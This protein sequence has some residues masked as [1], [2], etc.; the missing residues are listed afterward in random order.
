MVVSPTHRPPLPPGNIPGTH[1]CYRLSQPQ[2]HSVARRYFPLVHLKNYYP[3]K[4]NK[5]KF[6][7]KFIKTKNSRGKE[8]SHK[9]CRIYVHM[10][11]IHLFNLAKSL[12]RK[13]IFILIVKNK[14]YNS[15]HSFQQWKYAY[16][17]I[18]VSVHQ[19]STSSGTRF[20]TEPSPA[21][22]LSHVH[23]S[24]HLW[25]QILKHMTN[26]QEIYVDNMPLKATLVTFL[27]TSY[28]Q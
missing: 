14:G 15:P 10:C 25:F 6:L 12:R 7:Q 27:S 11:T 16:Q 26:L 19:E 17:I 18:I 13:M 3:G 20:C 4:H 24:M 23:E 2:G 8:N 28:I 5:W 9:L 1:F 21:L 22:F